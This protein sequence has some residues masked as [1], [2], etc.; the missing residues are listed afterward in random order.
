MNFSFLNNIQAVELPQKEVVKK[1]RE[2]VSKNPEGMR[3]RIYKDGSVYPSL[4][5]SQE[6]N[7]EYDDKAVREV[8]DDTNGFDVFSSKDWVQYPKDVQQ[9]VFITAI[10][11]SEPQVTLFKSVDYNEDGTPKKSVMNQGSKRP[12]II[13][14]LRDVYE[15]PVLPAF[16][17][18]N[19]TGEN[20]QLFGSKNYVDLEVNTEVKV[21]EGLPKYF[22]P[23]VIKKGDKVG[24]MSYVERTN[25]SIFP[26][27][28]VQEN[29][30]VVNNNQLEVVN[31]ENI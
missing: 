17:E 11:K 18:A 15:K 16:T 20:D 30:E 28:I 2:K 9:A 23:K 13:E 31:E 8:S 26:L 3:I 25:L 12:E 19:G 27:T 14:W 24:Q 22:I 7:L 1:G 6:F 4:E 29:T 21:F 5:L 10:P